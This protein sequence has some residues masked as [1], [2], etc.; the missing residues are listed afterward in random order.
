[1]SSTHGPLTSPGPGEQT[2]DEAHIERLLAAM[3][4][5]EQVALLAGADF[6]ITVPVERLGIPA[7]KVSDGP[8]GARGGG[9]LVGGTTAACFPAGIALAATWNIALVEQIG[10]ALAEEARSKGVHAVPA[11]AGHDSRLGR[12]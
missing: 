7:I 9:T 12:A 11:L 8:N 3:T 6:W 4:L 2:P 1:M 10:Q 5:E